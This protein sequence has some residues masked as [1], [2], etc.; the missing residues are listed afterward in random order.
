MATTTLSSA[1]KSQIPNPFHMVSLQRGN[2]RRDPPPKALPRTPE[3]SS[4]SYVS[5]QDMP[6][7]THMT[8][9]R[10]RSSLEQ[11]LKTATR[12]R[13]KFLPPVDDFA[14][15][16]EMG[17]GK[18]K[19]PEEH[20]A[21]KG[22]EK[23]KI[24]FGML[25]RLESR[26]GLHR[27]ARVSTSTSIP[28]D[29]SHTNAT[30]AHAVN[31]ADVVTQSRQAGFTSFATPSLRQ[32]S[33]SSPALHLSSQ[34][35]TSHPSQP[36]AMAP[37]TNAGTVTPARDRPRRASDR[38][39]TT[40]VALAMPDR[41]G[42]ASPRASKSRP[43]PIFSTPRG[44]SSLDTPRLSH[45]SP[46][47]P[48]TP[49]PLSNS[50]RQMGDLSRTPV[51]AGATHL[52]HGGSPPSSP[53][54]NRAM[55]SRARTPPKVVT[56]ASY[57]GL[58]SA[59]A[60]D[61]PLNSYSPP[62][63]SS[64]P[65]RRP[66]VDAPRR[67]SVDA[68][69]R[70][71]IDVPQRPSFDTPRRPS[72]EVM[73]KA[74]GETSR[75]ASVEVQRRTTASLVPRACSPQS[76]VR[77]RATSPSQRT[78]ANAQNRHFNIST[79]SLISPST[80]EQR[81]VIRAATSLLC[82]ELRKAPPHLARSDTQKEWAEVEVRL[83]PLIRLERVWGKSGGASASQVAAG[84]V[85]SIVLN[86]AGEERERKL[87]CEALRD[88]V[89]LC[90]LMNKHCP[91]TITRI[92]YREDGFKHTSNITR[93]IA[94]CSQHNVPS[95]DI[96]YRDDLIQATPETLCRVA[97]TIISSIKLFENPGVDRV[98][99]ITGQGKKGAIMASSNG[100]YSPASSRA[101]S[102]TPN[103]RPRSVSPIS[104]SVRS[105]SPQ[106]GTSAGTAKGVS[107][108]DGSTT[109]ASNS[110]HEADEV[111]SITRPS[112]NPRSPFHA[113]SQT[114]LPDDN[115]VS[116]L[117][118]L[119]PLE[120]PFPQDPIS[121]VSSPSTTG[122]DA[123]YPPRQS[124][125]S[126]NLTENTNFSSIFDIR[127]ASSTN[128]NKFGTIRTFTTDATSCSEVPS[129]TQTEA[130][131][132]AASMAEEMSR[133][134]GSGE[135]TSRLRE[136]HPSEPGVPDLVSL[137]EEEENS[138]SACGSS[139]KDHK[140]ESL[141]PRE[142]LQE[143]ETEAQS[144]VRLG[145]GKWPDDFL[146]AFQAQAP[147]PSRPIP[148]ATS[149][150]H[151]DTS[152][153]SSPL[154]VS[155]T[156]KLSI[157]GTSRHSDSVES[158]ARRPVHRS[159]HSADCPTDP[160]AE[161]FSTPVHGM[162]L[163]ETGPT[164]LGIASK[165]LGQ[166][167]MTILI[168]V[169]FPRAVSGEHSAR[170]TP[171]PDSPVRNNIT[172]NQDAPRVRGRFQSDVE[173]PRARRCS[174]PT[175][176]D[177]LGRPQR[178]RYES[179]VNLGVAS[180][181][182]SASDL[183]SRDSGDGGAVR[184]SVIVKEEGKPATHFQ[185]G[186]CIGRG[187]F[188]TVYRAL[189]LTTGQMVAVKRIRLEGLKEDEVA[190]LMRE[191]DFM[192]RL[193]HPS[194]V[195]YEGMARDEQYLN[196][197]LEYAESGSLGQMLKAF[198]KLNEHLVA[199]YVVKILEGLHYLHRCDVVHCDLKAANILTT[200]T[201][202]I[203]LSDFGV[204]L[205]LKAI[206]REKD[207]AGTPNWMAPEVIE[208]KGASTKS[209]IWSLG[210]TVV[211]LLTGRPPFGDITNTMTVMFRIVE[212][213]MPIPEECSEPLKD[214]LQQCFQ[215]E[216]LM[217]PDAERLCEHPWLKKNWDALKE[218]RPQDSIPFLRRVSTD[219]Q[220]IDIAYLASMDANRIDSPVSVASVQEESSKS[221]RCRLSSGPTS[222][223][224]LPEETLFTPRDHSF[225]RTAFGKP[226][227]CRVCMGS[228]KRSAVICD[229][230]NLITHSM[231]AP[232]APPTC[233]L[234]A[235]LLLYAQYAEQGGHAGIS[236]D[237]LN[238]L[239]PPRSSINVPSEVSFA[240]PSPRPSLD[241]TPSQSPS[242]TSPIAYKFL[243][244]FKRSR[245]SLATE[246][247]PPPSTSPSPIP[248]PLSHD[249]V[250][251]KRKPSKLQPNMI[252]N[253]RPHSLSSNSTAPN[254]SSTWTADS[255]SSRQDPGRKS[256]L[257]TVEPDTDTIPQRPPVPDK[258]P[259]PVHVV[260]CHYQ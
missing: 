75:R 197:V 154:S 181:N 232:E 116:P 81:E 3:S 227:V 24:K 76:T 84:G 82:K 147:N 251:P 128:Q 78:L 221:P 92:D 201:G 33:V 167:K 68:P 40:A 16:T 224:S 65:A 99:V 239:H 67:P 70:G 155:Q 8:F 108:V 163:A 100:P 109:P 56:P 14:T 71:P 186:N 44:R 230:C 122:Y 42:A 2:T 57:Q 162:V 173:D 200:K 49:K 237:G 208:L 244:P 191:V 223:M 257:S 193:S 98:K 226:M 62:T 166:E 118:S 249:D 32:A 159:N 215:K 104:P 206:E 217:R 153:S 129:F 4:S 177:E 27:A 15:I 158:T 72:A 195:K 19:A 171:S 64:T 178:S 256:V 73:R 236:L 220:K 79:T 145:K 13:A 125:T 198:G 43:P 124:R 205:N 11:S 247:R 28:H 141:R 12:S 111:P 210:C 63:S 130:S 131:S 212:D 245:S 260:T 143:R 22:Q 120:I 53:P 110:D 242:P 172:K 121:Q 196:I 88:G 37:P 203:K 41:S 207:V 101:A 31:N 259:M 102:S 95:D 156:R 161:E 246:N 55:S 80:P 91:G 39:M 150:K 97:R 157:V 225:I 213:E 69:R 5:A 105:D 87:F 144:R 185:L 58:T 180:T 174:R 61:L 18:E 50:R 137:A 34:N 107:T 38:A 258:K 47:P 90:Q 204:S 21:V 54:P 241:F 77:P 169:P 48:D 83:Q 192:K 9:K 211:E 233:D 179:M 240:T 7:T 238:G 96:F 175:S 119:Q 30:G 194:I 20:V 148:I 113:H 231:C 103:L 184:Q 164:I 176:Y 93:F 142:P 17:K 52:P 214:F 115:S 123:D 106:S 168:V 136:R 149:S 132:V 135:P 234:R 188:G 182:A 85:G 187:Q 60:S 126:S 112:Q 117:S 218:L 1:P 45:D 29:A 151:V 229:K 89:V 127:R 134:R 133:R 165:I 228:I 255:Q 160:E 216:P 202:N 235:Q 23:D 114:G 66:S 86:P 252:S 189:N 138:N 219:L 26:V 243:N 46:S 222:P 190:Q 199:S 51:A 254:A 139:F 253:E 170:A 146:D 209:D 59:S 25:R 36:G 6:E 140:S 248:Q 74:S 152:L 94:A 35:L 250:T 183:L 10:L